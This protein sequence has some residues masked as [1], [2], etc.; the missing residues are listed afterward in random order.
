L[1]VEEPTRARSG[2]TLDGNEHRSRT[3]CESALVS[4]D[5][6]KANPVGN[7][8][9]RKGLT[10]DLEGLGAVARQGS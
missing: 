8:D 10:F 4:P 7:A 6:Q 3:K 2:V 1:S 9:F 5:K